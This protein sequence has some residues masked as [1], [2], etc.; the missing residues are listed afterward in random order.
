MGEAPELL[1]DALEDSDS[2]VLVE[3]APEEEQG[4][5]GEHEPGEATEAGACEA[6][7]L[8][9][10]LLGEGASAAVLAVAM[11][12]D[13]HAGV[14]VDGLEDAVGVGTEDALGEG[15]AEL[16][17]DGLQHVVEVGGDDGA[18]GEEGQEG[19][20]PAAQLLG[21]ER[22][23]ELLLDAALEVVLA[24]ALPQQLRGLLVL[25]GLRGLWG[26]YTM[27]IYTGYAPGRRRR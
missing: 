26:V 15:L 1:V 3:A 17:E 27:C 12:L 5:V 18:G 16:A 6:V 2:A 8:F 20:G 21:R 22:A 23:A 25:T 11:H 10:F 24:T 9:V 7:V 19:E 4:A 14:A 13:E